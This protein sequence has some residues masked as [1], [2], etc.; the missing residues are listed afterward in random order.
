MLPGMEG[1]VSGKKGGHFCWCCRRMRP[2]ER[3]SGRNH[4][5]HLCRECASLPAEGRQ[6]RQG[7][8]A[9]ERLLH[10]GLYVPRRRRAQFNRFLAHPN[11]R[12]REPARQILAEQRRDGEEMARMRDE[13]EAQELEHAFRESAERGAGAPDPDDDNPF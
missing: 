8:R 6:Y 10:G 13:E 5:L 12:V 9:I 4:S 3:F 2:N 1:P 7:E 11:A